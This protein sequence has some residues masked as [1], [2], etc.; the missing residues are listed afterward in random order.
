MLPL[1]SALLP[2]IEQSHDELHLPDQKLDRLSLKPDTPMLTP[3][4]VEYAPAAPAKKHHTIKCRRHDKGGQTKRSGMRK[5]DMNTGKASVT[6]RFPNWPRHIA[7]MPAERCGVLVPSRQAPP[8]PQ[9][10]GC[11][12]QHPQHDRTF[13]TSM[14]TDKQA[15]QPQR[16]RRLEV[17]WGQKDSRR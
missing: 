12:G 14:R 17:I 13:C 8:R 3:V 16:T 10:L 2:L 4:A 5:H 6:H 9:A 11:C 15:Q 1:T 7:G